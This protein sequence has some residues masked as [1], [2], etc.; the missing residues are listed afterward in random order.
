MPFPRA[1]SGS[2]MQDL[3]ALIQNLGLA[4]V[5]LLA[6]GIAFWRVIV[7]IKPWV[8]RLITSHIAFVNSTDA[9]VTKLTD[10][11]EELKHLHAG[12]AGQLQSI[13]ESSKTTATLL[14]RMANHQDVPGEKKDG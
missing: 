1:L 6:I 3:A 12:T 7:W 9:A 13:L 8:E 11:V 5:L 10:S 2:M 4:V 14:Q